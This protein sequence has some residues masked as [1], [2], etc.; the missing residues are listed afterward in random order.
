[1][2]CLYVK[3]IRMGVR[4]GPQSTKHPH[5]CS[6]CGRLVHITFFSGRRMLSRWGRCRTWSRVRREVFRLVGSATGECWQAS[7]ITCRV[8]SRDSYRSLMRRGS[9]LLTSTPVTTEINQL[10]DR[11]I[12]LQ[13]ESSRFTGHHCT[14]T[15]WHEHALSHNYLWSIKTTVIHLELGLLLQMDNINHTFLFNVLWQ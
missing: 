3:R 12:S 13:M 14:M 6:F 8:H 4:L 11:V 1:M 2:W 9:V 10:F 7:M 15:Q 5:P